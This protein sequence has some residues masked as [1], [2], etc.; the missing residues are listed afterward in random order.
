MSKFFNMKGLLYISLIVFAIGV[1]SC[2]ARSSNH[3][4]NSETSEADSLVKK[5]TVKFDAV[6]KDF[7]QVKDGEKVR[8]VFELMNTGDADLLVQ[9]VKPSCGCTTPNYDKKPIRPG[10]KGK[11]EVEFDTSG[12]TGKQRKTVMVTTNTEPPN[13]VLTFNCEVMPK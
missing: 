2:G 4:A 8:L 12:R 1:S 9:N 3:S 7:G 13:T 11:I 6:E 10:K 5:T